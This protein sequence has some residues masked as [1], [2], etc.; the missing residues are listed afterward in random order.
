MGNVS[1][2]ITCGIDKGHFKKYNRFITFLSIVELGCSLSGPRFVGPNASNSFF[3]IKDLAS[4]YLRI[5]ILGIKN[6]FANKVFRCGSS[7]HSSW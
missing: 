3:I 2:N 5:I 6:R 4:Y 7:E 1:T